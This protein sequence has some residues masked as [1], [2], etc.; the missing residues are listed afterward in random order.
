MKHRFII[1][2]PIITA[3]L[4]FFPSQERNKPIHLEGFNLGL[5]IEN[6]YA[7]PVLIYSPNSLLLNA[8]FF[9]KRSKL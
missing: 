2:L 7:S 5:N 9:G 8:Q 4:A 1:F 6:F 3:V